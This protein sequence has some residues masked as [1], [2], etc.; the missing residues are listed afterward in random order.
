MESWISLGGKGHTNVQILTEPGIKLGPLWSKGRDLTNWANHA[1][2]II[3]I[4]A[5]LIYVVVVMIE[6]T[7]DGGEG[8][9]EGGGDSGGDDDDGGDDDGGDDDDGDI[10]D[11]C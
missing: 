2:P 7:I 1:H 8:G 5:K 9:G 4:V 3:I 11:I 6:V 10:I